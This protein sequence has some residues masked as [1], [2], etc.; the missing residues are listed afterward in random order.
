MLNFKELLKQKSFQKQVLIALGC[1]IGLS[2]FVYFYVQPDKSI[3]ESENQLNNLVNRVRI[4]YRNK[5]NAWGLNTYSAIQN[6]IVPQEMIYGRQIKNSLGKEVLLGANE[7]GN[8]VMPG[9]NKIAIVY[10]N[11]TKEECEALSSAKLSE[12]M[13]VSVNLIKI[14]NSETHIFT[15]GG[16]NFL[17]IS[18]ENAYKFCQKNNDVLWEIYL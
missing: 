10:K 8:T 12:E 2:L 5:P 18:T 13:K 17:P 15:W 1:V 9:S 16:K 3:I 7:F 11:L 6:N 14:I 4:F